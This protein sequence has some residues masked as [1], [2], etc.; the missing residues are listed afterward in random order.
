MANFQ[1]I[2]E[3]AFINR[4]K[5]DLRVLNLSWPQKWGLNLFDFEA[6]IVVNGKIFKGRGL[7]VN[8][9]CALEIAISEAMERAVAV[10]HGFNSY[11]VACHSNDK[12]A[13]SYAIAELIERESFF[14]FYYEAQPYQ[15]IRSLGP[16]TLHKNNDSTDS[17]SPAGRIIGT[18]MLK[19]L[20]LNA[21]FMK[22]GA[23]KNEHTVLCFVSGSHEHA[24]LGGGAVMGL[25]HQSELNDGISKSLMEVLPKLA[26]L[27]ETRTESELLKRDEVIG[28]LGPNLF[29]PKVRQSWLR[30]HNYFSNFL[31]SI[32]PQRIQ[33][34]ELIKPSN[35][36]EP[37]CVRLDPGTIPQ[38][39]DAPIYIYRATFSSADRFL[40]PISTKLNKADGLRPH[41]LG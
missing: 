35:L 36:G 6:S 9:D 10:T 13:K 29:T 34:G 23:T 19:A 22:L 28:G 2:S 16:D 25:S 5:L 18:E 21:Q 41:F 40:S 26:H 1:P 30:E 4:K 20:K 38:F 11:G 17:T 12:L 37:V 31:K 33:E 39:R 3:F 32:E 24:L 14:R 15:L 7:N 8:K 27:S